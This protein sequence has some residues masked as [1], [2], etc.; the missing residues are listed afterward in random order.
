MIMTYGRIAVAAALCALPMVA[1]AQSV[2]P[3]PQDCSA[4]PPALSEADANAFIALMTRQIAAQLQTIMELQQ[5]LDR[6][7]GGAK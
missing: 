1:H 4:K 6:S 2:A 7:K 3:A 5:T